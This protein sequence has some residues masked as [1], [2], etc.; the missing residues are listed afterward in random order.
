MEGWYCYS[1]QLAWV[2][3]KKRSRI[4]FFLRKTVKTGRYLLL[5]LWQ[6]IEALRGFWNVMSQMLVYMRSLLFASNVNILFHDIHRKCSVV[7]PYYLSAPLFP[8][9]VHSWIE[10]RGTVSSPLAQCLL[11]YKLEGGR[12][13]ET[14]PCRQAEE[15][16][17][18]SPVPCRRGTESFFF[19]SQEIFASIYRSLQP[20]H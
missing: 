17:K 1:A 16:L 13:P 18:S 2:K 11:E 20:Q 9:S 4:F 8:M 6:M 12:G 14:R 5:R 10:S 15:I 3:E 19:L 7:Y